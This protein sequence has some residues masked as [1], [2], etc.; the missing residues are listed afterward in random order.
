M[1]TTGSLNSHDMISQ[2]NL[3]CIL[4]GYYVMFLCGGQ[5]STEGHMVLEIFFKNLLRMFV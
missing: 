5:N 4:Y 2:V 3:S 1:I